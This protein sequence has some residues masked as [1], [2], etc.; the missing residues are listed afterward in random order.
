MIMRR[1]LKLPVT[2]SN[3]LLEHR[4]VN[5]MKYLK[6]GLFGK[7]EDRIK[8]IIVMEFVYRENIKEYKISL[9]Q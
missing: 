8:K 3:H 1:E 2:L 9:N 5:Q 4:I 7:T 6:A